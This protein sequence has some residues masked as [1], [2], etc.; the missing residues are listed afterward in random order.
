MA[1]KLA[2]EKSTYTADY[3][4]IRTYKPMERAL[5]VIQMQRRATSRTVFSGR[6]AASLMYLARLFVRPAY[7]P[8]K[9]PDQSQK[10]PNCTRKINYEFQFSAVLQNP[11]M[12][13]TNR[14]LQNS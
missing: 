2:H 6:S 5:T 7:L 10:P 3:G 12:H 1:Y 14:N 11:Q 4:K 8:R 9:S 13:F